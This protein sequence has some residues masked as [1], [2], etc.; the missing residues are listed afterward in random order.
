MFK[1]ADVCVKTDVCVG[2]VF[3]K[4]NLEKLPLSETIVSDIILPLN[5]GTISI[6]SI[7]VFN[8]FLEVIMPGLICSEEC[9]QLRTNFALFKLTYV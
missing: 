5:L 4:K 8:S 9:F 7:L 6:Y 1:L 2:K 3:I